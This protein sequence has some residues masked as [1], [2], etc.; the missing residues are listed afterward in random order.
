MKPN[1]KKPLAWLLALTLAVSLLPT[2]APRAAAADAVTRPPG[3]TQEMSGA[4]YWA[5]LHKDSRSVILTPAE[6]AAQNRANAA[7][8]GN[9]ITDLKSEP[10][11]FDG[12]A[13]NEAL[14][15]GAEA[16]AKYYL[17]WTYLGRE[18]KAAWAEFEQLIRNCTDPKATKT[19][20]V[21][22]GIAVNRTLLKVFPSDTPIWDDP[23][24]QDFDYAS[25]SAVAV[26]APLL[27]YTTSADGKY[28][29]A[30]SRDCTGW[31]AAEDVALCA[32]KTEWLAAWDLPSEQLLVVY[33]NKV[34]TDASNTHPETARRML[35]QGTAL[36]LVTDLQP[37]QLVNNRSPYHNY[38][39]YLPVR[40]ADG[41]YEKQLALLPET[42]QV[43]VGYLP[44]TQENIAKVA[45]NNLGDTY[46]WGGMLDVEDCSG[47]VRTVYACFGLNIGRNG[48]WQAK[49]DIEKLDLSNTSLEEKCQILDQLPLG[50]ALSFPGHEMLYLGKVDGKYYVLSTASSML[51]P[52]TGERLRTRDVMI[53]ALDVRRTNGKTWLQSLNQAFMPAYAKLDGKT[54]DFPTTAWYH[55]GVAYALKNGLMTAAADDTFGVAEA[56][57]RAALVQALWVLA[58]SPTAENAPA[59]SDVTADT[60][61]A[62]AI[63]WAAAEGIVTGNDDGT[64]RPTA[65]LTREQAAAILYRYAQKSHLDVSATADLQHYQDASKISAYA[66]PALRWACGAGLLQGTTAA[67]LTPQGT[68]TRAQLAVILQRAN[69]PLPKADNT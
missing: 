11:T 45:L 31:I 57:T 18:T 30:R 65:A 8:D 52:T 37:G 27:L 69:F 26:N 67:T 68:L 3:V 46:G 14:R 59:F 60:D 43:S 42:A 7:M 62:N 15:A 23:A 29:Y 2:A 12:T 61:G 39:V 41:S 63:A 1:R 35:T 54:Y 38:V 21:R 20:P 28:Y 5:D 19:M 22:Y 53:N 24:D 51:S 6:I 17:G 33:G 50:S 40:R 49:C 13:K 34:Y 55:D 9:S 56:T 25:L 47:L 16:D 32:D 48:T 44:L 4:S 10:T 66:Q 58:G 36:E 64:F